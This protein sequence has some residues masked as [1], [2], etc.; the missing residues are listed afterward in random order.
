MSVAL[1]LRQMGA[2]GR[3]LP[4]PSLLPPAWP[5]TPNSNRE[6]SD[7]RHVGALSRALRSQ[8]RERHGDANQ[9]GLRV[10]PARQALGRDLNAQR[11]VTAIDMESVQ[12]HA[13][14][15]RER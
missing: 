15:R 13:V 3:V 12:P 7:D 10:A 1:M 6:R 4:Q 8:A 2:R 9:R 11:V 14:E 5:P